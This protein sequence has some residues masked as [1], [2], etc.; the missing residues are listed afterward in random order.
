MTRSKWDAAGNVYVVAEGAEL[1]RDD[2]VRL[3]R[4]SDGVLEVVAAGED[5]AEIVI[6]NPDGSI[7]ELSGNGTRIAAR[8]LAER[9]GAE[10]VR[11]RVGTREVVARALGDGR[12]EQDLGDVEVGPPE[13]VAGIELVPVSVGNPHAVVRGDPDDID[14][15]GP[16]LEAHPRFPDRTNVQVVRVDGRHELTARVWERGVGE[17]RSS[18]TSAVAVAAALG[19]EGETVV[20]FPGGDLRV[21]LEGSRAFLTGPAERID[22][23]RVRRA[24]PSDADAVA[25][26][27]TA[28]FRTLTFLPRLHTPDEDR[29]FIRDVVLEQRE[30]WVAEEDERI[31]G[32]AALEQDELT[33]LYVHPDAQGRGAGGALLEKAKERR[34]GGLTFW[35]FQQNETARRFYEGRGCRVVRLTDGS[36]NEERTPDA[37]YEWLP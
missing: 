32:F 7:A 26:V 34:P 17:T 27:F 11:I 1:T 25:D 35:V 8:W 23:I 6:W 15:I 28:S 12:I 13:R 36:G 31:V 29:W 22:A 30:V 33:H 9:T 3:S 5:W 14:R 2:A 10:T 24:R 37:L 18:G 16:L 19:G 4:G 20:H 21:R